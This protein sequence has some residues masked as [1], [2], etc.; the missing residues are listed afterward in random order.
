MRALLRMIWLR[1]RGVYWSRQ[2]PPRITA[3][4]P[5]LTKCKDCGHTVSTRAKTCQSCGVRKPGVAP[6]KETSTFTQILALVFIAIGVIWISTEIKKTSSPTIS[7]YRSAPAA[8]TP[9][10]KPRVY[11]DAEV[12]EAI[13]QSDDYEIYRAEFTKAATTLLKS[14]RCGRYEMTQYGGFVKSTTTY[15]KQPVYFIYCGGMTIKNRIYLDVSSGELF[16]LRNSR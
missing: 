1:G 11:T 13:A 5:N 4:M 9:E 3:K 8:P 2:R 10:R 12:Q 15:K 6:K 14:R 16:T 7:E